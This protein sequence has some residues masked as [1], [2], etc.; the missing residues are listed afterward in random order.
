LINC[1]LIVSKSVVGD[2]VF[3]PEKKVWLGNEEE[4]HVF[5]RPTPGIE[6]NHL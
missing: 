6:L 2:M 3:D 5:E 4:L 1:I